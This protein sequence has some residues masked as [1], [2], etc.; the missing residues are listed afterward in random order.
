M[1]ELAAVRSLPLSYA[2]QRL[3]F[4]EQL[5]PGSSTYN[6]PVGVRMSGRLAVEALEETLSEVVRRHEVLRTSFAEE[7]GRPVQVIGEGAAVR[8]VVE[9][10]SGLEKESVRQRWRRQHERKR[11]AGLTWRMGRC[12]GC[13]CCGWEQK[14]MCCC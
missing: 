10:L 4:L 12:C 6:V 9:E 5:E 13:G 8:L 2:Q 14:S 7:G 3:W 1:G 11:S